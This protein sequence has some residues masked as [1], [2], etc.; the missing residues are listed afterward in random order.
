LAE[1]TALKNPKAALTAGDGYAFG[2]QF[3]YRFYPT[4]R[5][6]SWLSTTEGEN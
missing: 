6:V 5:H 2:F 4:C 3:P 1:D